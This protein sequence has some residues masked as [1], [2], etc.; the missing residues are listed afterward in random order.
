MLLGQLLKMV[1][2]LFIYGGAD[3]YVC[4]AGTNLNK[5][6]QTLKKDVKPLFKKEVFDKK[7]K[8]KLKI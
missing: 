3:S 8:R 2:S 4:V 7:T 5:F 6:L 1:N